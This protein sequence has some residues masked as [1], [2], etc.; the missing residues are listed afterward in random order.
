MG[1][2]VTTKRAE[3]AGLRSRIARAYRTASRGLPLLTAFA[4]P[5]V[6]GCTAIL[7]I[8][9]EQCS[10]DTDCT[11]LFGVAAPYLCVEN[12]CQRPACA[13][14]AE[15]RTR[16][17]AFASAICS[18][19]EHL[20]APA[21]CNDNSQCG[22]GQTCDL[23]S[24]RCVK[25]DCD[26]TEECRLKSPSPTVQCTQGFCVDP[27]WECIGKP[28]NRTRNA[29][30]TGTIK[31]KLLTADFMKPVENA[32]WTIKVC[33]TPQLDPNCTTKFNI[34]DPTYDAETGTVTVS[35]LSYDV[36]VRMMFD[37]ATPDTMDPTVTKYIPID[38]YTQKPPVGVTE[39]PALRVVSRQGLATLVAAFGSISMSQ[40][41]TSQSVNP[42]LANIY[43]LVFDCE[44]KLASQ[45]GLSYTD[46]IDRALNPAPAI[47]FFNEQQL[48][49]LTRKYSFATGVFS[50]LNLPLDIININT[51]LV[52]SAD[53][54][55]NP[56]ITRDI[57]KNY[58]MLLAKYRQ[59]TVHFY[60]RDYAAK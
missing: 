49:I 43:G 31:V 55:G 44:D 38:F 35:G 17:G 34:P 47:L 2:E 45:V 24:N 11:S 15:C 30:E 1:H 4:L 5:L 3:R 60:P 22:V 21:Q 10:A 46:G 56:T 36:P 8:E 39:A 29:S 41:G 54:A 20:C 23:T 33:N 14:D 40:T 16:G 48:P 9:K 32:K 12:V 51:Q 53:A 58:T 7:D 59:T 57:R 52:V 42:M 37:E 25:R 6:A 26:T 19:T 13:A 50:T 18:E 28:D 27:T